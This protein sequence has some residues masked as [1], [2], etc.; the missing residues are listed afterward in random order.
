M[1]ATGEGH[2]LTKVRPTLDT[3]SKTGKNLLVSRNL[4]AYADRCMA[5]CSTRRRRSPLQE[6]DCLSF[7]IAFQSCSLSGHS[8]FWG[9]L[10]HVFEPFE[11]SLPVFGR[12]SDSVVSSLSDSSIVYHRCYHCILS[13]MIDGIALA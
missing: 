12:M 7:D 13:P 4:T 2:A 3:D 1:C 5:A 10:R 8:F 6:Y 11:E 9:R